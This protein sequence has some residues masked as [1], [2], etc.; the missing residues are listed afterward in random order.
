MFNPLDHP[1]LKSDL[2]VGLASFDYAVLFTMPKDQVAGCYPRLFH[3]FGVRE[4]LAKELKNIN[5]D[6]YMEFI[7]DNRF[8]FF[9]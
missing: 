4:W 1:T 5:M 3:S 2:V 8:V 6:D 7:V 9:G